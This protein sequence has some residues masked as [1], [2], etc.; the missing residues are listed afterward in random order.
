MAGYPAGEPQ[1]LEAIRLEKLRYLRELQRRA[2]AVKRGVAIYYDDPVAFIN[3]CVDFRD[4][5]GLTDYQADIIASLPYKKREA[6]R[7]PHGLGKSAIAAWTVWW[8]ALTRDATGT[9][10]K[11]VTTAGAWRQLIHY[12]WPEIRKWSTRLKW[13]KIRDYPLQPREMLSLHINL[14]HG[15][16]FAAACS[17]PAL[18]EGCHADSLLFVYDESKS[19]PS[20]TFDAC[21]GAFSGTGEAYAL[22]L[23]TPGEP[24]GRFYDIC[25]RRKGYEDWSPRHVKL[26]ESIKAGRIS[27]EWAEQRL[28]QW[29]EISSLY[30]NRVLGEFYAGDE[31]AII[32]LAWA[33]AAVER[34]W[35]WQE[36]GSPD[37][38][39]PH[40][41]GV[42]PARMGEDRTAIAIRK[43][44]VITELRTYAKE[45]TMATVGR[46]KGILDADPDAVALVDVIGVGAGVLDRLREMGMRAEP[47]TASGKTRK[48]DATGELSYLNVRSA[49]WYSLREQLDPSANS[50]ICLPDDEDL[51]SDL[52]APHGKE[53]LSGGI[54]RME[55]KD[56]IRARIGRSTDRGDAVVQSFWRQAGSWSDVY[57]VIECEACGVKF[58]KARDSCPSCHQAVIQEEQEHEPYPAG[59][60]REFATVS[61]M[62]NAA[63]L[64]TISG[65]QRGI[66]FPGG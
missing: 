13:E 27:R 30:Q 66:G 6:V 32:P 18:I 29:G 23:S 28:K 53:P 48:R 60:M 10:W 11:I 21:E 3:D 25:S 41:V 16:A 34:W 55:S 57:G 36:A 24:Q 49:A 39:E 20:N 44:P 61:S 9:D 7:G 2:A 64:S 35:E 33:E 63:K 26:D 14:A 51:L 58:Y 45:D 40:V 42:D 38:G 17:N 62:A 59:Q 43:G 4:G 31:D 5:P 15:Q 12:L 22:A 1:S 65:F 50:V 54:L 37:L 8:F 19:I 47:F 56:E 52:S 46:V